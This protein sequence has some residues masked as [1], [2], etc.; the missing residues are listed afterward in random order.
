MGGDRPHQ[1]WFLHWADCM[2]VHHFRQLRAAWHSGWCMARRRSVICGVRPVN[3]RYCGVASACDWRM[4]TSSEKKNT[5]WRDG[6]TGYPKVFLPSESILFGV[7]SAATP[8]MLTGRRTND[9]S[10]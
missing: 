1:V 5:S 3:L 4:G 6:V 7:E 8:I 9:T 10:N 2:P